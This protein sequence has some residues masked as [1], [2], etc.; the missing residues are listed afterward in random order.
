MNV[1][2][3]VNMVHSDWMDIIGA[4]LNVPE[5]MRVHVRNF[6]QNNE[7]NTPYQL[8][9]RFLIASYPE[10]AEG[11]NVTGHDNFLRRYRGDN[12]PVEHVIH[13][14]RALYYVVYVCNHVFHL[15]LPYF[16]FDEFIEYIDELPNTQPPETTPEPH[17]A[18]PETT[19]EIP[20]GN[21]RKRSAKRKSSKKRTTRS[22]KRSLK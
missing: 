7:A 16:D 9:G 2:P 22:K 12:Q 4:G 14:Q 3:E 20:G 19:H 17:T 8:I 13:I 5:F 18:Q 11:L 15:Q 6:F 21:K 10:N 1:I